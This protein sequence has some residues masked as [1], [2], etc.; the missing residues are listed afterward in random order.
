MTTL[1]TMHS[2]L[3]ITSTRFVERNPR[4]T[5]AAVYFGLC[6]Y[7]AHAEVRKLMV[8]RDPDQDEPSGTGTSSSEPS[9]ACLI[10]CAWYQQLDDMTT[11]VGM[12]GP[13]ALVTKILM[14]P[15][16]DIA[17]VGTIRQMSQ[18]PQDDNALQVTINGKQHSPHIIVRLIAQTV[19]ELA[20]D[21]PFNCVTLGLIPVAWQALF[22]AAELLQRL[23]TMLRKHLDVRKEAK[24]RIATRLVRIMMVGFE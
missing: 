12:T 15:I 13:A 24:K 6:F 2:S 16:V 8:I 23:G 11:G 7:L 1:T 18:K 10:Y 9:P 21:G 14:Q 17:L 3:W 4:S 19:A 20:V 22:G 5:T